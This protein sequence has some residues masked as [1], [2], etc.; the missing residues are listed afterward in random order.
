MPKPPDPRI[1]FLTGSRAYGTPGPKS[2]CDIVCL[3]TPEQI[4]LLKSV[5]VHN[6]YPDGHSSFYAGALNL[7]CVSTEELY[8]KWKSGTEELCGNMPV[9]RDEAVQHFMML[10]LTNQVS[11]DGRDDKQ[12]D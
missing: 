12:R 7:I 6:S 1:P 4:E 10:G 8:D 9:T 5:W 11:N 3:L 2:D